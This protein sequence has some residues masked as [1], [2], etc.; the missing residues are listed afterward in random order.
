MILWDEAPK[1]NRLC[2][3]AVS[4]LLCDIRDN[5][6]PFGGLLVV[7]CG[8]FSQILL[9]HQAGRIL[10]VL[11]IPWARVVVFPLRANMELGQSLHDQQ[12]AQWLLPI[13]EGYVA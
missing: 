9:V 6:Q 13:G 12:F 11:A 7:L 1:Q 10:L 8:D 3:E 2:F 4:Y 5:E